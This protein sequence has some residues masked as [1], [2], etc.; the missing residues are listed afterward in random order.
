MLWKFD[1]MIMT[2]SSP[3]TGKY[4]CCIERTMIG[5][6]NK[7]CVGRQEKQR[8]LLHGRFIPALQARPVVRR[9]DS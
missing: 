1:E 5:I 4:A 2:S 7:W 8:A 3:A 9:Q 6:G